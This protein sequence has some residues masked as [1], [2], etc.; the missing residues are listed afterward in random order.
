MLI[1]NLHLGDW[2]LAFVIE[3]IDTML[4]DDAVKIM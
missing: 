4:L 3:E 1:I 2:K